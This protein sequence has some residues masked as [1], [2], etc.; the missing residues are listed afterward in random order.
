MEQREKERRHQTQ[1]FETFAYLLMT[2][3]IILFI[4][5]FINDRMELLAVLLVALLVIC[6]ILLFLYL[7]E[8]RQAA[9]YR[10]LRQWMRRGD[11][12]DRE[13]LSRELQDEWEEFFRELERNYSLEAVQANMEFTALQ[14]QINPHFLYNTLDAIRSQALQMDAAEIAD[15]TG[16]LSRF[17]RYSIKN[18]GDLVRL[19]E[20]L[21]NVEDYFSIQ[22]YRFEDR[23][24]MEIQCP[25]ARA[26]QYYLPKMTFQPIVENA[27]Y[28]GLEPRKGKGKITIRV[29]LMEK[30]MVIRISDDGIGMDEE[31]LAR[32]NERLDGR[33]PEEDS[34][35]KRNGI[36]IYNVNKRLKLLF[37]DSCGLFYRSVP[38][39]GT[40][41]DVRV[42]L[43]D[44]ENRGNYLP[45]PN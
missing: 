16:K 10:E 40:D 8:R 1:R 5:G 6:V 42:P 29:D 38:G 2:L 24:S 33:M 26:M 30:H 15:M 23:F 34:R 3:C 39:M 22:H 12:T 45:R 14:N 32:L 37:G 31:T 19:L 11:I 43:V 28:H 17:F 7:Q 4:L 13:W 44:E 35:G 27:L 21:H 25:D 9:K 18:R 20:E 41:V 36:A